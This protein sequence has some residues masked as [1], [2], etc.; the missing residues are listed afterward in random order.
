M[1][2]NCYG[3]LNKWDT[4]CPRCNTGYA[5][6]AGKCVQHSVV[7]PGHRW[8]GTTIYKCPAGCKTC[9][10]STASL[11][12]ECMDGHVMR[13]VNQAHSYGTCSLTCLSGQAEQAKIC[14]PCHSS[15]SECS[16]PNHISMCTACP[17]GS[18]ILGGAAVG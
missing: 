18:F 5:L 2:P 7:Y 3:C 16:T 10:S 11:C 14:K 8:S 17:T 12:T 15:C 9:T 4:N 1:D 13:K 6:W